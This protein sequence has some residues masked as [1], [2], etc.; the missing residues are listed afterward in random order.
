MFSNEASRVRK[1]ESEKQVNVKDG[2]ETVLTEKSGL[3]QV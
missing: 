1:G 2:D 3:C